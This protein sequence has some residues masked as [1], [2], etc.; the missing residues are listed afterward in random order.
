MADFE[1]V[2]NVRLNSRGAIDGASKTRR[3][4][5]QIGEDADKAKKKFGGLSGAIGKF[6]AGLA[7]AQTAMAA[8]G[9][10]FR[11]LSESVKLAGIQQ[12]AER[13]LE[14]ALRNLGPAALEASGGLAEAKREL[15]ELAAE[16]QTRSNF[17]DEL[18]MQAQSVLLSF[19]EVSGPQGVKLLTQGLVDLAAYAEKAGKPIDDLNQVA[20]L[21]GRA[22]TQ[23]AGALTRVGVSLSEQQKA[24]FSAA[25][26]LDRVRLLQ[27][28]IADNAGGLAEATVDPFRQME[29]AIGD[30]KEALGTELRGALEDLAA[31][32]T[33]IAQDEG[34]LAM[35]RAIG[36]G[37]ADT[38]RTVTELGREA[39]EVGQALGR[40]AEAMELLESGAEDTSSATDRLA[41]WMN[42]LTVLIDQTTHN[43][44][45]A[46]ARTLAFRRVLA[47]ARE[48]LLELGSEEAADRLEE[49][50]AALYNADKAGASLDLSDPRSQI[51]G[52][53]RD[54]DD[55][56][57]ALS[58][59]SRG[60][61]VGELGDAA[62]PG[63]LGHLDNLQGGLQ[64]WFS[65]FAVV[66][67]PPRVPSSDSGGGSTRPSGGVSEAEKARREAFDRAEDLRALEIEHMEEGAEKVLAII[68]HDFKKRREQ[69]RR[70]YGALTSEVEAL[71]A[72]LQTRAER[73][74][75]EMLAGVDIA[76]LPRLLSD[77]DGALAPAPNEREAMRQRKEAL[78]DLREEAVEDLH[79]VEVEAVGTS[80]A[81]ADK[82]LG[83]FTGMSDGLSDAFGYLYEVFDILGEF[84]DASLRRAEQSAR[85]ATAAAVEAQRE[86]DRLGTAAAQD[87]ADRLAKL[88]ELREQEARKAFDQRKAYARGQALI[89]GAL[90]ATRALSEHPFPA[91]LGIVALVAAQ[92]AAQIA[93][94]QSQS[95]YGGGSSAQASTTSGNVGSG[96]T[97]P[98]SAGLY[99]ANGGARRDTEGSAAPTVNVS[100]REGDTVVNIN[101]RDLE[102]LIDE[103]EV[104]QDRRA[105]NRGSRRGI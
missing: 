88:A 76:A 26:G 36:T 19:R 11:L 1:I 65:E 27:E 25:E 52:L 78:R 96:S 32:V 55:A 70:E 12:I 74:A 102:A 75:R 82:I 47:E 68:A 20:M 79:A 7:I 105:R 10:G 60:L 83:A 81:I 71:F 95:F 21:M 89:N 62:G 92:T 40:L 14:Q 67:P 23:G 16:T 87:E 64:N 9:A 91:S 100:S 2:G 13:R 57:A 35:V 5:R 50:T 73:A 66:P 28:I 30:V 3:A 39:V 59:L 56:L 98:A 43:F 103:I 86:A 18:I 44:R 49:L 84:A 41:G 38:T 33:A 80:Q 85:D 72:D 8:L 29:N 24:A 4:T 94:I 77:L 101:G 93:T 15:Q 63:Q 58:A 31:Q 90:A 53:T 46:E 97:S 42:V 69:Y 99:V 48:G 45:L 17:G 34:F 61:R 54:T 104:R 37:V 6:V 51:R 22:L